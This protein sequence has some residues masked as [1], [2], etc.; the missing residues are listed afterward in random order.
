V[1]RR[2]VSEK[3]YRKEIESDEEEKR[4]WKCPTNAFLQGI[5]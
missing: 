2:E 1:K 3:R 4:C 5:Q